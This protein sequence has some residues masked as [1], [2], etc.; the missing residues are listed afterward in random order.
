MLLSLNLLFFKN[1]KLYHQLIQ[2]ALLQSLVM[3]ILMIKHVRLHQL[4]SWL[5]CRTSLTLLKV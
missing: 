2:T 5:K 1:S 3:Q 4:I